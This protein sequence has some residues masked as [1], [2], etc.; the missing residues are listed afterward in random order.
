MKTILWDFDGVI[1]D[2]NSIR[3]LGFRSILKAF[4]K[5]KVEELI[6]YHQYNGGL[7]RYIKI[8]Y[9]YN[10]I[11]NIEISDTEVKKLAEEFSVIMKKKLT[12]KTVLINDS[13]NFIKKNYN[14][15][16]FHI[17]S[18][19]DQAELRF[20]CKK[21]GLSEYF[22][23]IHGSPTPKNELVLNL[24]NNSGYSESTVCLI[25]DSINDYEAAQL[26]GIKFFGYNNKSLES[27]SSSYIKSFDAF[28]V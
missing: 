2:S 9:F 7:S 15:Y 13:V 22:K 8:R 16:N 28:F 4:D 3:D 25:G 18:G 10:E 12:D 27:K 19:S 23:S 6:K 26:N 17:V 5:E 14:N 11:M 24:L 21:L 1:I 20:L